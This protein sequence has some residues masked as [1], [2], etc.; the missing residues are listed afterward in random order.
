MDAVVGA[1]ESTYVLAHNYSAF[2]SIHRIRSSHWLTF[3]SSFHQMVLAHGWGGGGCSFEITPPTS[4]SN[5]SL[6]AQQSPI[7]IITSHS[8]PTQTTLFF[9]FSSPPVQS[10]LSRCPVTRLKPRSPILLFRPSSISHSH[11]AL[12]SFPFNPPRAPNAIQLVYDLWLPIYA[13]AR[14]SGVI[15]GKAGVPSGCSV[16]P[17][18]KDH[19]SVTSHWESLKG[20]RARASSDMTKPTM[21][22]LSIVRCLGLA[23]FLSLFRNPPLRAC[24]RD[25]FANCN[26][27][28]CGLVYIRC[29]R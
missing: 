21:Q 24:V 13:Q 18:Q 27:A 8:F 19:S 15:A 4:H 20:G 11:L 25:G 3:I 29:E 16:S 14:A 5:C 23:Q 7:S 1:H 28:S 6:G 2:H 9:F 17:Q 22:A 12:S 26:M 10:Q